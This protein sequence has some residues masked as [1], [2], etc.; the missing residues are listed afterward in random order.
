MILAL[1]GLTTK[2]GIVD[3][4]LTLGP[5]TRGPLGLLAQVKAQLEGVDT[6][7]AEAQ[8]DSPAR[9]FDPAQWR[10]LGKRALHHA[11]ITL[12]PLDFDPVVLSRAHLDQPYRGH[13]EA[14]VDVSEGAGSLTAKLDVTKLQGGVIVAPIEV[15]AEA[16]VTDHGV[17][18]TGAVSAATHT[19]VTLDATAPITIDAID[20]IRTL[21][22]T[23]TILDPASL[24]RNRSSRCSAGATSRAVSSTGRSTSAARSRIP[25]A[26]SRSTATRVTIPA[27]VT[28]RPPSKLDWLQVAGHWDGTGG[29]LA[30]SGREAGGGKLAL[31]AAGRPD[32][33]KAFVATASAT[34][35]DIA[36]LVA[37][38]VGAFSAARGTLDASVALDGLD[39]SAGEVEGHVDIHDGRLPILA[40]VRHA[41]RDERARRDREPRGRRHRHRKARPRRSQGQREGHA[42]RLDPVEGHR[43]PRASIRSRS[44][45]RCNRRSTRRSMRRSPT[46]PRGAA[47]S[48]SST[49]A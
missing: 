7:N 25:L 2:Q 12:V 8:L 49:A 6:V 42:H 34:K 40:A 21:P 22:L 23:G 4:D 10:T 26:I 5:D 27:S 11:S 35:F 47:T 9:P 18:A 14:E 24:R 32:Q 44:S 31:A 15:H 45:A 38:A 16:D 43:E 28:G 41:A 37:F 46:T 3:A 19:F 30:I 33:L 20:A 1:R 39:L 48:R 13:L 17:H 36:P 29:E